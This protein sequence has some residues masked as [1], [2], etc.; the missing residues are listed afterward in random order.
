MDFRIGNESTY[1]DDMELI[2][3]MI[4]YAKTKDNYTGNILKHYYISRILVYWR[5]FINYLNSG[6]IIE[7]AYR[8][9]WYSLVDQNSYK[10]LSY[11]CD[12]ISKK[13]QD[14]PKVND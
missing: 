10:N 6:K 9:Q 13:Y 14:A 3:Y 2:E 12:L 1:D 11:C 4:E 5:K 8:Y 7:S